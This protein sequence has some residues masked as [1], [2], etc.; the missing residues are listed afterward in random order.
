[1]TPDKRKVFFSDES[2]ILVALREGL[3]QMYSSSNVRYSVNK[4]EEM[5][6][7][8]GRSE[9]CSPRQRSHKFVKQ[10]SMDDD[11]APEEVSIATLDSLQKTCSP[12]NSRPSVNR[13]EEPTKEAGKS[14]LGFRGQL[15]C[16]FPKQSSPEDSAPE[17][18]HDMDLIAEGN[19]RL[20]ALQTD[21]ECTDD[22][23][24]LS[25][26]K[27]MGKDFTL[28]VHSI[29]KVDGSRQMTTHVS[30]MRTDQT[31][32]V[33][34]VVENAANEDSSSRSA[35]VQSSL[36]QFVTVNKRKHEDTSTML[37]EMPVLRN[38]ALHSQSKNSTFDLHPAVSKSPV[39]HHQNDESAEVENSAE[40]DENVPSKYFRADKILNKIRG[41]ISPGGNPKDLE[42]GEV[43]GFLPIF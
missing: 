27:A 19:A 16:M 6:K 43:R 4:A 28:R 35:R 1:M 36:N 40:V 7:E 5:T 37:S 2:S 8:I 14:E 18:V 20:K 39:S 17:E 10:S 29:K 42:P 38:Q 31:H 34:R 13:V 11:D 22:V 12:S 32:S 33:S 41:P 30:S 24:E 21:S 25:H 9:L 15:S 23:E 26:E 3:Q